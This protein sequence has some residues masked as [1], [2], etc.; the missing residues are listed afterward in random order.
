MVGLNRFFTLMLPR[1][2]FLVT[3]TLLQM[4][5]AGLGAAPLPPFLDQH[6][7]EC[8][9]SDVQ[10]GGLDLTVLSMDNLD[11]EAMARWVQVFDRVRSGE[12]PPEKKERPPELDQDEFLA[13]L[14]ETLVAADEA[15][16]GTVMRRLNR[17]EFENT[18]NDLFGTRVKVAEMLPEDGRSH[19]FDNVGEAL[20]MSMVQL[21]CYMD[22]MDVVM[23]A[24]IAQSS[25]P[26]ESRVVKA[27][28]TEGNE[29]QKFIG[30]KWL[31]L[32][33]GA[34]VFFE[35]LGYPTGTLKAASVKAAGYYKV[36]VTGYAYQ[37][38]K[39][40]TFEV[41]GDT[42]A[43]GGE[44]PNYGYFSF[45]PGEPQTVEF[46][47]WIDE[48]YMI[49]VRPWGIADA[50]FDIKNKGV[51][52][53]KGPGLA[54]QRVEVEG[55]LT[56]EFPTRGHRLLFDGLK[57]EVDASANPK[58]GERFVIV[59][60]DPQADVTPV[61]ARIASAAFRRPVAADEVADFV[62][63]FADFM[64][65][66]AEFETAL[67]STVKAIFCAPEFLF[68]QERPGN[69]SDHALATRLSYF[70]N[71]S[72]PD[73]E[74]LR[75]AGEG[76]LASDF[77]ALLAQAERLMKGGKFERFVV[78]YT[79]AWLN[80]RDIE[81]TA[82]DGALFPEFDLFL[83]N[84]MIQETRSYFRELVEKNLPVTHL[85][86]SDFAMLNNRLA[87]HYGIEGVAGPD[88]QRVSLPPDSVRGSFLGQGSVLKVSANGTNTSPV[89]RG[90]WLIERLLGQK[91]PPPPP[92]VPGV[93]P[94]IRGATTLRELLVKHRD[95]AS[96]RA[97]HEGID[98]PGF[99]LEN[100]NP[101]G[102]WRD[103]YRVLQGG[104]KVNLVVGN[105][106]VRYK[107]GQ[108]V[109]PSGELKGGRSFEGFRDFR[110][111]LV[112]DEDTLA[113]TLI[114]KLLTFATGREMGFSD[115]A[116]IERLVAESA[117]RSHGV[118]EMMKMVVTSEIFRMK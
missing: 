27:S 118:G 29:Y 109:D 100:F 30:E 77:E 5:H 97:C 99:A 110:E 82:P 2:P 72:S 88:L 71:R 92:G 102:G 74:L 84:S 64:A 9:D 32:P 65:E 95:M 37:T 11:H 17:C 87:Q 111:M 54:V 16:K 55:P 67:R 33:D 13:G 49:Q 8:H 45:R 42:F 7:L 112:A 44:K 47:S 56:P 46:E 14:A 106:K 108:P 98:P 63:L 6:C 61:I 68:L 104:E 107:L 60:D 91:P 39:P 66:G 28:Y 117:E 58:W 26:P 50:N 59:S 4:V 114:T 101:I 48:R 12:M 73:A 105:K 23:D 90:I 85:V 75:V 43:R 34:V 41:N 53:Y 116:E 57:R 36:R 70:L 76:R 78:D 89:V 51:K 93:E 52:N 20:G 3:S 113:R 40:I 24:A 19:E 80:L 79:D 1:I 15:N 35:P 94:D 31:E 69:L 18:V 62:A 81:F 10:K 25:N 86:K 115:R 22:A 38:D 103:R 21:Q 83:Q 96:C